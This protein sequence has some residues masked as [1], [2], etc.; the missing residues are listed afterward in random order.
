[1]GW[2]AI[3]WIG[4]K[5]GLISRKKSQHSNVNEHVPSSTQSLNQ[6]M[7][8]SSGSISQEAPVQA[9]ETSF[10][11]SG[12]IR[13]VGRLFGCASDN[14]VQEPDIGRTHYNKL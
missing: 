10:S 11:I 7:H 9:N 1:M 2:S 3:S 5:L 4:E 14:S 8:S 13:N 6:A 12:L